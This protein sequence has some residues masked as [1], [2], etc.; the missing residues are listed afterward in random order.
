M[1]K[2]AIKLL[3]GV[4]AGLLVACPPEQSVDLDLPSAGV[5]LY[6]CDHPYPTPRNV[7]AAE[8]IREFV[9]GVGPEETLIVLLSGGGSAYTSLPEDGISITELAEA[10]RLLQLAGATIGELNTVRKHVEQLKGGRLAALCAGRVEAY[11]LSDVMGDPLDVIASGPTA[12]DPSTF[13]QALG[14]LQ[15]KGLSSRLPGVAA[16]LQRGAR[17]EVPETPKPGDGCFWR[18]DNRV[19]ASNRIVVEAVRDALIGRGFHLA[20]IEH[21]VEGDAAEVGRTLASRL[22]DPRMP[23]RPWCWVCGGETTVA[24]GDATGS[25]GPSQELALA[26]AY[27]LAEHP[28]GALLALSTDGRDGPTDAAG[29]IVDAYT[30]GAISRS[31]IDPALALRSHDSHGAL[32]A[33]GALLRVP[34]TGTNLNHVAVL[35]AV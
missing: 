15:S 5:S 16:R 21:G 24:V 20:G 10:T 3:G 32:D 29:A 7:V 34:P 18:V 23:P 8:A 30:W 17:A 33:A 19:I 11:I 13:G 35:F 31:G 9:T 27:V 4:H 28:G 25:G 1:A 26:A 22:A 14:V 12:P 2:R 6:P